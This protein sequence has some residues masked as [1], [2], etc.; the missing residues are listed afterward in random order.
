MRFHFQPNRRGDFLPTGTRITSVSIAGNECGLQIGYSISNGSGAK[1]HD[2]IEYCHNN[3]NQGLNCFPKTVQLDI[4]GC[5]Y[6]N[7]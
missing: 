7:Q 4:V 1:L 3:K 5:I 6:N 2:Q